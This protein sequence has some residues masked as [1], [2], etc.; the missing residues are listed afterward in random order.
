VIRAAP[1]RGQ[2]GSYVFAV[3]SCN[4]GQIPPA[5]LYRLETSRGV[6]KVD[7][8]GEAVVQAEELAEGPEDVV[9]KK[10]RAQAREYLILVLANG[11]QPAEDILGAGKKAGI[12]PWTMRRA[13]E[14]LGVTPAWRISGDKRWSV[15]VPPE[16]G[17]PPKGGTEA[18]RG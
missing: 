5:L 17:F 8:Q 4:L 2:E 6:P 3:I 7:W 18:D 14:D 1:Y 12:E 9:Q 11:P 13:A 16:K 15:W 10:T